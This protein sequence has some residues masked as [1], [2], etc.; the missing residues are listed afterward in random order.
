MTHQAHLSKLKGG[1]YHEDDPP[2]AEV[3]PVSVGQTGVRLS[4]QQLEHRVDDY[5]GSPGRR[6][7]PLHSFKENEQLY[8]PNKESKHSKRTGFVS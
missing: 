3:E 8:A 1:N 7:I 6:R 2:K 4:L 5:H